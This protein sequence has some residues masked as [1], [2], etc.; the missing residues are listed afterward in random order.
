MRAL[1][2]FTK[3]LKVLEIKGCWRITDKG[4]SL[5]GEYCKDLLYLGV[6]D[7][8]DVTEASLQKLRARGI[9]MDRPQNPFYRPDADVPNQNRDRPLRLQV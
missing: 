1:A 6:A 5:V 7:C 9:K 8:R 4:I 2:S 3:R